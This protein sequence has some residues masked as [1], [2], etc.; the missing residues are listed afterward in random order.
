VAA[1]ANANMK[2]DA[3]PISC[4]LPDAGPADR[5]TL[6]H[7][8]GGR[9]MRRLIRERIL[10]AFGGERLAQLGDAARLPAIS[11]PLA[12]TTDSFVVTP[13]F[14]AGGDIGSL[15]V[16]GTVNDLAVSGARPLWISLAAIVE[17]GFD[18]ATFDRVLASIA[19]AAKRARVEIVTG[20]TKVVP[21]GAADGLF[22][23]TTGI[24]EILPP[25][26]PG[27]AAFQPGDA[28][29]ISGPIG[30][31]GMA[32][33]AGREGLAFAPA[34][35]SDSAPLADAVAALRNAAVPVR[36][37]RD[38]TRGGLGAVLHEWAEASGLTLSVDESRVP[39]TPAVRGVCE[40]LGLDP[41]HVA[42]E[43]TMVVAVPVGAADAAVSALRSVPE[44]C[45]ATVI[46]SVQP[47]GLAPVIVRRA[48]GQAVPL[49]EPLGSPLPRIC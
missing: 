23:N 4:P 27:P 22:L 29:I 32:V 13:L 45:Q 41:I 20:D 48:L 7:G 49:D 24:G 35:T 44:T 46:G 16:Y 31:H 39:V 10:P 6:A 25:P 30:C 3:M 28:L 19:A 11:G 38:A 47:H 43:G 5:I 2:P 17:E 8:E 42:N 26:V 37:M 9:L 12:L 15:A 18:Q 21:R 34:P 33:M 1:D 14:F 36:A 40:V